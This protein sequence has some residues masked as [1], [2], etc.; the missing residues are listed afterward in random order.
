MHDIFEAIAVPHDRARLGNLPVDGSDAGLERIS[1]QGKI[2]GTTVT[3]CSAHKEKKG[4]SATKKEGK[5]HTH[6]TQS[7]DPGIQWRRSRV[8]PG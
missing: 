5:P 1:L 6:S 7:S 2:K 3:P 8:S 4:E